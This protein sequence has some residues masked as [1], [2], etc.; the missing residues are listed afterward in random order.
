MGSDRRRRL[1][2]LAA[3][4]LAALALRPQLVG[5]GPLFGDI[6]EDLGTSHAVTG[7]LGTIPVLCMGLFA[8]P[9]AYLLGWVG[10][11]TAIGA[12]VA[13]IALAGMARAVSPGAALV[14]ALTLPIGIGMGLAGALMPAAVKER[15]P[16]RPAFATGVYTAG[17]QLGSAVSSALAVPLAAWAGGWRAALLAFGVATALLLPLWLA[18]VRGGEH[19]RPTSAPPR[20]PWRSG[21]VWVLVVVFGL[22]GVLYYG[23]NSWLPE[24][25][26]E[27]GWEQ[28]D[29]GGLLALVNLAA[30]P[31]SLIVPWFADRAGSRRLYLAAAAAVWCAALL[32]VTVAPSL[33]AV[34]ALVIGACNGSMFALALTLPLDVA[35]GPAEVGA[36]AGLMLG[37]GYVLSAT[38]PLTLGA[39]RDATGSFTGVL[40]A[41]VVA[42]AVLFLVCL[43]LSRERLGQNLP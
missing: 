41:L 9:A 25:Y 36:V 12:C 42:A 17:I 15:F 2:V 30:L 37:A 27:R 26:V 40:W 7:L 29:A 24:A 4:F 32:A 28:A 21:V 13:L 33:A 22:M 35:H 8:P 6:Q 38:A 18:L 39:V 11:R 16:G 3:L 23:V 31:A 34:W 43:S 20:L 5:A 1:G 19:A 10:V 14:V